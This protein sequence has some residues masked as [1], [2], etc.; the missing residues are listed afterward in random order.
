MA[1]T[2]VISVANQKGG[3]GKSTIV[4]SLGA[5]LALEGKKVLL[6][7]DKG[8][9]ANAILEYMA[10]LGIAAV[11]PPKCNRKVQREYS[12]DLEPV[13]ISGNAGCARNFPVRQGALTR[14][15]FVYFKEKQRSMTGK[16]PPRRRWPPRPRKRP[17]YNNFIVLFV[18]RPCLKIG[19][20]VD[21]GG[22]LP[23]RAVSRGN[24]DG[25]RGKISEAAAK[26][27]F[28]RRFC[29]YYFR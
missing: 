24:P 29:F 14:E 17:Q 21:R 3:V 16:D 26:V 2:K 9:D 18:I 4:Y 5:G 23:G 19:G 1:K 22:F 11:I 25:F 28:R 27:L 20:R 15:Y 12:K 6:P 10:A 8:Y 7:A 13:F